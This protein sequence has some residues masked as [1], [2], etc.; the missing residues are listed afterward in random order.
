MLGLNDSEVIFGMLI[1]RVAVAELEPREPL[2]T[3]VVSALTGI[4]V[5]V[6]FADEAPLGT[7]TK[8][9]TP[10]LVLEELRLTTAPL[11]PALLDR[12]TVAIEEA[13]PVTVVGERL[14]PVTV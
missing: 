12:V 13:P 11:L 1:A 2:I 4:D 14:N 6:K 3:A 9:G 8:V 7:L 5:T 10:A